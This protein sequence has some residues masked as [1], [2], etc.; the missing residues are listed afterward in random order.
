MGPLPSAMNTGHA[1]VCFEFILKTKIFRNE[2][3][4]KGLATFGSAR[5]PTC[6]ILYFP[7][8]IYTNEPRFEDA[9]A[10]IQ[11]YHVCFALPDLF[12]IYIPKGNFPNELKVGDL[13]SDM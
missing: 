2:A 13:M 10:F 9:T 4:V 7:I 3:N 11:V 12:W 8:K 6:I 1:K 5:P